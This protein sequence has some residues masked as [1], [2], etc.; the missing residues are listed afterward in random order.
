MPALRGLKLESEELLIPGPDHMPPLGVNP[1]SLNP[2]ESTQSVLLIPASTIVGSVT[3]MVTSFSDSQVFSL[4]QMYFTTKVP[5]S[6]GVKVPPGLMPSA[7]P[8]LSHLPEPGSVP[9]AFC[10]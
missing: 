1:R 5:V 6:D 4:F 2:T 3:L 7:V 9:P 10:I 8:L